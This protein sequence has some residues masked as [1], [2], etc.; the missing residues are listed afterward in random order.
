MNLEE[1]R[2]ALSSEAMEK[3]KK[4]DEIIKKLKRQLKEKDEELAQKNDILVAMFN[5]CWVQMKGVM[6]LFC[7][8]AGLCNELRSVGKEKNV[9]EKSHS[10]N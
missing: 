3:A 1:F 7:N 4:Q 5:R 6:C 9:R 8:H 2:E 10:Q